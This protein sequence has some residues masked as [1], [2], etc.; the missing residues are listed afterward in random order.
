MPRARLDVILSYAFR[1]LFLLAA[2]YAVWV[3]AFWILVWRGVLVAPSV[4][5]GTPVYWHAHEMLF[6]FAH[7][8]VGGFLLTAVA[9]WTK[10]PPVAGA[11]LA[12]LAAL[13]LG[14]RICLSTPFPASGTTMLAVAG[15]LDLGYGLLLCALMATEV[16]SVRNHRNYKIVALLL[17]LAGANAGFYL[18]ISRGDVA[19]VNTILLATVWLFVILINVVAGRIIPAFTRNWLKRHSLADAGVPPPFGSLDLVATCLLCLFAVMS[20][21]SA[22]SSLIALVGTATAAAFLARLVRW[23]G[24]RAAADPLVWILHVAFLW[25]PIGVG[26]FVGAAFGLWPISAGVHALTTGAIATMIIAVA[27]RA[28]LGHTGRPLQSHPLL[29]LA[30]ACVTLSAITRVV[31]ATTPSASTMLV[32]SAVLWCVGFACF[33]LRYTPILVRERI[34]KQQ[35]K[36]VSLGTT[37]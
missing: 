34:D 4:I 27:G 36:P 25:I 8:A 13:W 11:Q 32:V 3:V 17:T 2:I 10:R 14:A 21:V 35:S 9:N 5:S 7:V 29:N 1:P 19:L 37:R 33:G 12:V 30:F 28:A 20:T 18:A 22:P 26:L 15:V 24:H 6:G 31:A 16:F 23:Q